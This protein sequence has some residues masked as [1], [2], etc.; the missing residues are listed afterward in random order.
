M[1]SFLAEKGRF[2]SHSVGNL[3]ETATEQI[4]FR[5]NFKLDLP[6]L[7]TQVHG[8]GKQGSLLNSPEL[9][10]TFIGKTLKDAN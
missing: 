5:L 2:D 4:R 7:I 8:N 9:Y 1:R 10:S 6:Y 3:G